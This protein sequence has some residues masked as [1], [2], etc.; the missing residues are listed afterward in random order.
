MLHYRHTGIF[1]LPTVIAGTQPNTT[2]NL[3]VVSHDMLI[4]AVNERLRAICRKHCDGS[5]KLPAMGFDRMLH[6]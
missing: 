1:P 3:L 4:T 2:G 6:L 5:G